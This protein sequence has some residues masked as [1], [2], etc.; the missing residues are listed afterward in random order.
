MVG[1]EEKDSGQGRGTYKSSQC[2]SLQA[3]G[4]AILLCVDRAG[5]GVVILTGIIVG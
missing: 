3:M 5:D 1:E 4:Q 2:G